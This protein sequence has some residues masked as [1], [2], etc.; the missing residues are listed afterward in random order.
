MSR[1]TRIAILF[2]CAFALVVPRPGEPWG[3]SA[4]RLVNRRAAASL[5]PPLRDLFLANVEY[6]AE[7]SID[8]DLWRAG[9]QESEGPNHFLDMD[10]FGA[11]PFAEIPHVEAEHLARNGKDARDKGRLP[12]RVAEVYRELVAAFRAKD[13]S[14]AL[15]RAAI[16]GHYVG[17]AHVPLHAVLNYDGKLTKQDGIH[18]RW[19][20]GLVERFARQIERE[21]L[22]PAA[23]PVADPVEATFAILLDSY[24]GS[25][26]VLASDKTSAGAQDFADTLEDDRYDDGY[27]SRLFEKDGPLLVK[28]LS[29]AS[30]AVG[31]FWLQAWRDAGSPELPAFRFDYVRRS[32]RG[33]LVTL[34]GAS[35]PIV[36]DAVARGVMP[37]LARLRKEG[38]TARGS[39]TCLPGKTAAGHATVFTGAWPDRHGITGNEVP[40][41]GRPV[42][43]SASGFTSRPLRAEPIWAAAARQGLEVAVVSATQVYP[44]TPYLEE[45]RFG[46][47][48]GRS[49]T[50]LDG[51][52]AFAVPEATTTAKDLVLRTT[53]GWNG[54]LPAHIGETRDFDLVVAGARVDGLLY[55]DPADP[56][57]GFDTIYLGTGKNPRGGV[58]L[59]P[60]PVSD[61]GPEAFGSL[62]LKVGG[63]DLGLHFRLFALS[64]NASEILLYRAESGLVRSSKP[65]VE[66]AVVKA[67]GGF[68]GNGGDRP[69]EAGAFGPTLWQGG[70]G[71]AERRYLETVRLV[72][73]QFERL[74]DFGFDRLRWDL[75]VAYLPYPDEALHTWL[76]HL[77][78]TLPGH[79]TAVAARLRPFLDEALRIVDDYVGHLA[80]RTSGEMVLAV[81]ADHG[82]IGVNRAVQFNVA[83]Q[84]AGLLTLSADGGIDLFRTKVVYFPGNSGYF[85]LNRLSRAQGIVRPEEEEAVL[86]QLRSVLVKLRDPETG[87]ALV[88]KILD[89]R[90]D[91]RDMGLGGPH[92]GDLYVGLAPGYQ[93]SAAL[94][95]DVVVKRAPRGEHLLDVERREMHAAFTVSGPG[96]AAGADLGVIKQVDVA[97]TVARLLGLEPPAQA[98]GK[99]LREAL[100]GA[101]HHARADKV[102]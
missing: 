38:A 65:A 45:K 72:A 102:N 24:S 16:L 5:P 34:D 47:H 90:R 49:L 80:K 56:V 76:G 26:E 94:K 81:A 88:T 44:F 85:L 41:P 54:A 84:R 8:P 82:L 42:N 73:R 78:S 1:R 60:Q 6:L 53:V 61:R 74:F 30:A 83:L 68:T 13:P 70:D 2:G 66:A 95:G 96:V 67:T 63:G 23:G 28:R 71:T 19:E 36:D 98:A 91:A 86:A 101:S 99:V 35:A 55:D 51:Y 20:S 64:P 39:L 9:G 29:S 7:H 10:A 97:P 62:T 59:K 11:Y 31:S 3:F 14:K 43:E 87:A 89:P 58:T 25:L 37:N 100:S 48:Y 4:H 32:V 15:E 17:D 40:V 52:Q 18:G 93:T 57:V 92:G 12:W 27:Y 69:Y 79:D 46:G 21:L 75:L 77:D 22:P 33:V 50:L